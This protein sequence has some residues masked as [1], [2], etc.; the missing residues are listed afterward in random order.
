M[1]NRRP[2]HHTLLIWITGYLWTVPAAI[3]LSR[4]LDW[5]YDGDVGWWIAMA[6]TA[7][8]IILTEPFGSAIPFGAYTI[9]YIIVLFAMTFWVVRNWDAGGLPSGD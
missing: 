6:Y 2:R 8:I 7:P 5:Q 9:A 3:A 1:T 4:V